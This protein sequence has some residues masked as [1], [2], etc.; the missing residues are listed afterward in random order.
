MAVPLYY[1][2]VINW[3]FLTLGGLKGYSAG[4]TISI[5][6]APLLYGADSY[7][8]NKHFNFIFMKNSLTCQGEKVGY[9][10]KHA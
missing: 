8:E 10:F 6:K 7:E 9:L 3:K 5:L 2:I 1:S 4:K